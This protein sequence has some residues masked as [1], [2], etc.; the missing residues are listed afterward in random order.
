[1]YKKGYKICKII[2]GKYFSFIINNSNAIVEYKL[3]QWASPRKLCGVLS[4]FES[5]D[6]AIDFVSRGHSYM[7]VE[8]A[9]FECD[10][11]ETTNDMLYYNEDGNTSIKM[12]RD[13]PTGTVFSRCVR[14]LKPIIVYA[15]QFRQLF[16]E[17]I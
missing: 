16:R 8:Y 3:N 5:L 12:L 6:R 9:I 13:C 10:Y 15:N 4:V 1:M 2:D 17:V 7:N 11:Y 14:L